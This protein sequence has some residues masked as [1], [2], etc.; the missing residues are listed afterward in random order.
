MELLM[1]NRMLAF[2]CRY[3]GQDYYI[4][5]GESWECPGC[6]ARPEV[7]EAI[8][9]SDPDPSFEPFIETKRNFETWMGVNITDEN[10]EQI[11]NEMIEFYGYDPDKK[12]T[13]CDKRPSFYGNIL[14][15]M[16]AEH[17]QMYVDKGWR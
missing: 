1:E 7:W 11:E 3:C 13:M 4:E 2:A 6:G 15:S 16:C 9:N 14:G 10:R 5:D 12:C 17:S 8:E